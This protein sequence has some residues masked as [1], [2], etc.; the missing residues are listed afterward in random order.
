MAGGIAPAAKV[1]DPLS[2][3]G[4]VLQ[5][6]GKPLALVAVDWCESRELEQMTAATREHAGQGP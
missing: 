5:G 2:A 3:H 1:E 4:L 6:A